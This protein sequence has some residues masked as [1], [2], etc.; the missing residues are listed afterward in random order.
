[1]NVS[2]SPQ[3]PIPTELAKVKRKIIALTI[4]PR[5]VRDIR[6][7]RLV[8][9]GVDETTENADMQAIINEIMWA[10][11][12]FEDRGYHVLDVSDMTIE[13]TSSL[14]LQTLNLTAAGK[15]VL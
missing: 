6:S 2:I 8:D 3:V 4:Q 13:T 12:I 11:S 10:E 14:I 15:A 5:L 7:R 9:M 1:V